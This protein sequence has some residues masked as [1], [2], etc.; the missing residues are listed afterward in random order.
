MFEAVVTS[1][2]SGGKDA[3]LTAQIK[4]TPRAKGPCNTER[5]PDA[6]PQDPPLPWLYFF[7]DLGFFPTNFEKHSMS[8][9]PLRR[10]KS[11]ILISDP[12]LREND[13]GRFTYQM[14]L[15]FQQELAGIATAGFMELRNTIVR[16]AMADKNRFLVVLASR[17]LSLLTYVAWVTWSH[18]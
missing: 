8:V 4:P 16:F 13:S 3:V 7:P 9:A 11:Q 18:G 15:S 1:L 17:R 6:K 12:F 10:S 5:R 2:V 14:N